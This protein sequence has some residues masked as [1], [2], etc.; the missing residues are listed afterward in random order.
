MQA[1][2]TTEFSGNLV[3]GRHVRARGREHDSTGSAVLASRLTVTDTEGTVVL[4]GRVDGVSLDPLINIL[5][6][7]VDTSSIADVRFKG[8][9]GETIGRTA[10]FA[11]IQANDLVRASGRLDGTVVNWE[12]LRFEE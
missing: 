10:F 1:N 7:L 8:I 12:E 2:S 4:Q 3:T 9:N 5:G 11:Q 6:V